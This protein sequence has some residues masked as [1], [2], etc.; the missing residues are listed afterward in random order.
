MKTLLTSLFHSDR[1]YIYTFNF[2][3][4]CFLIIL[5]VQGMHTTLH[6][7]KQ[8]FD[9]AVFGTKVKIWLTSYNRVINSIRLIIERF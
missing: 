2:S 7:I 4:C 8:L 3:F 5:P 9:E 1:F 6:L